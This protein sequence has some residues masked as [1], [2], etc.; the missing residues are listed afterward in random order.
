[1]DVVGVRNLKF[2][3]ADMDGRRIDK[4]IVTLAEEEED[5][6]VI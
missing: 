1:G 4:L 3:V 6:T 2:E 5:E